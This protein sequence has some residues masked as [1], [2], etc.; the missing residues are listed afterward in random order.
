MNKTAQETVFFTGTDYFQSLL[1][2]IEQAKASI[3]LEAYIFAND[4]LGEKVTNALIQAAQRNVVVRLLVDGAGTPDW[5]GSI[6]LR[7]ENA[8]VQTRV[9]HPF[10]WRF[11]QWGRS[12]IKKSIL[13]KTIYLLS[14]INTRNHRKTCIIDNNIVYVGSFNISNCHLDKQQGGGNWLILGC[15]YNLLIVL[16]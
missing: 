4:S 14:N 10:P 12:K 5:G 13:Q 8:G 2:D 7:L 6:T 16:S 15:A 11:W 1:N 3:D 9:F